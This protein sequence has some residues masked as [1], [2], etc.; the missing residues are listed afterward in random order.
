MLEQQQPIVNVPEQP[1][2]NVNVPPPAPNVNVAAVLPRT[3]LPRDL[4]LTTGQ[5]RL[6]KFIVS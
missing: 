5:A 2:P 3:G 4:E 6:P 1:A